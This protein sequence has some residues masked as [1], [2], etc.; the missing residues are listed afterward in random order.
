MGRFGPP[1]AGNSCAMEECQLDLRGQVVATALKPVLADPSGRR[2]RILGVVSTAVAALLL[3]WLLGLLVVGPGILP[4]E[5][6]PLERLLGGDPVARAP[7]PVSREPRLAASRKMTHAKPATAALFQPMTSG[8]P[9]AGRSARTEAGVRGSR[10][11]RLGFVPA[12]SKAAHRGSTRRSGVARH[13]VVLSAPPAAPRPRTAVPRPGTAAPRPGTNAPRPGRRS[14]PRQP[15]GAGSA[16]PRDVFG[17]AQ[18]AP[19]RSRSWANPGAGRD[20]GGS[21]KSHGN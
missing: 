16:P 4:L 9:A 13:P 20:H 18:S 11:A 7:V 2:A 8:S 21:E 10:L 17:N 6:L 12:T 1:K 19:G 14:A 15:S 3:A 5:G